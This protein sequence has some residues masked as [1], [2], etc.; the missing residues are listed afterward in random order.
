MFGV[1]TIIL[2][3]GNLLQT[4]AIP[5]N[6]IIPIWTSF[7]HKTASGIQMYDMKVQASP[8]NI[9]KLKSGA[10]SKFDIKKIKFIVLK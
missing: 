7:A 10:T 6:S 3:S 2:E 4:D 9:I 8:P 5:L 1:G